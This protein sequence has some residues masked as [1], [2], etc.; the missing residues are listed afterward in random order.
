MSCYSSDKL[1]RKISREQL[2]SYFAL[3][4]ALTSRREH[5]LELSTVVSLIDTGDLIGWGNAKLRTLDVDVR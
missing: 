2:G 1:I 3:A 4:H 5:A